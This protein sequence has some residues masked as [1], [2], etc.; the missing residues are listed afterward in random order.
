[1]LSAKE[2]RT[3]TE[4]YNVLYVEDEECIR[5]NM[6]PLLEIFFKKVY[7]A[8]NGWIGL[9]LFDKYPIDIVITDIH[10]PNMN[11]L[12][13]TKAIRQK[14][15]EIP[16]IITTAFS[17][18]DYFMSSITLKVDQYLLKPIEEENAKNVF[19]KVSKMLEDR[20]KARELEHLQIQEKI[21][22]TSEYVINQIANAYPNPCII[23]T[24]GKVRYVNQA[25]ASLF[26]PLILMPFLEHNQIVH[27]LFDK[28]NGY[29]S[30]LDHYDTNDMSKNKVSITRNNKRKIFR[31]IRSEM[32]LNAD[33]TETVMYTFNDITWEEYQKVKIKNYTELLEELIIKNRYSS[34]KMAPIKPEPKADVPKPAPLS[35]TNSSAQMIGSMDK[36]VLRRSH[37]SKTTAKEYVKELDNEVLQELD[38]LHELDLELESVLYDIKADGD[39]TLLKTVADKLDAYARTISLLFQFDDL[40]YAIRSLAALLLSIDSEKIDHKVFNKLYIF[41]TGIQKDLANW[42][43]NIFL[44]QSALDIHYCDS[45]LFSSCLQIELALSDNIKTTESSEED[46]ELF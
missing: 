5:L 26:D 15:Q 42:R 6:V 45:S 11:G 44:D 46:F 8:E 28:K 3:V 43:K 40:A 21:N 32:V 9:E 37:T 16:V 13:M 39:L 1:M 2:I 30:N 34:R 24:D 29:L 22:D 25:F 10:M 27:D 31:I 23:Y 7:V 33:S 4:N 35:E 41:L 14:S 18:Q 20:K 36:E 38:E 12:E 19:Y 17:N